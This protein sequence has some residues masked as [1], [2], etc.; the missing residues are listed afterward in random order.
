MVQVLTTTSVS[1]TAPSH[2]G[3]AFAPAAAD[4]LAREERLGLAGLGLPAALAVSGL[5]EPVRVDTPEGLGA[6]QAF[7]ALRDQHLV[8]PSDQER[9]AEDEE[10]RFLN[11]RLAMVFSSRRSTPSFW[12]ITAFDWDIAP[13]PKHEEPAGILHSDAYCLTRASQEKDAAWRF[14]EFALGPEG[15]RIT[16]QSGRTVPSLKEVAESNAFLDPSAEPANSRAEEAARR[17]EA[18]TAQMFARAE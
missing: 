3:S 9:E 16:A 8:I 10:T 4:A 6:L 13:L 12:T 14:M 1:R 17:L 5:V 7:F 15:Q 2:P 11:G 18:V